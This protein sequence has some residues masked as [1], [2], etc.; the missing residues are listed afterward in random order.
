[1]GEFRF[2]RRRFGAGMEELRMLA[3]WLAEQGVQE[4]VMKSTAQRM[5][6]PA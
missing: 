6:D 2:E 1:V 3:A 5:E 4:T